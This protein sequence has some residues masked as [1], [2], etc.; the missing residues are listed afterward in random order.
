MK[1]FSVCLSIFILFLGSCSSKLE[2]T[3]RSSSQISVTKQEDRLVS[4]KTVVGHFDKF[5]W[6]DYFYAIIQTD[7]GEE[8]SFFIDNDEDCFLTKNYQAKLSIEYD[9]VERYLSEAGA[10]Y[11]VNIIRNIQTERTDLATW[12]K[13]VTSAEL[14]KCRDDLSGI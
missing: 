3:A 4:S 10:Y 13:S 8:I 5:I 6:G 11:P 14:K 7:K 2:F 9:I 12:R 1:G